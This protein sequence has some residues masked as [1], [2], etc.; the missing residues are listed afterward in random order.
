MK[1]CM[2]LTSLKS[3]DLRLSFR[4][5]PSQC[6]TMPPS[7]LLGSQVWRLR[8]IGSLPSKF[9]KMAGVYSHCLCLV[10]IS[11]FWCYNFVCSPHLFSYGRFSIL[12]M[13]RGFSLTGVQWCIQLAALPT[14][15][16]N[17]PHGHIQL[18]TSDVSTRPNHGQCATGILSTWPVA[19]QTHYH[20]RILYYVL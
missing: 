15:P 14:C 13:V 2:N 16:T 8:P 3:R 18:T 6:F 7:G 5:W 17:S 10:P 4:L 20:C 9:Y 1:L 11:F 12:A 19:Q